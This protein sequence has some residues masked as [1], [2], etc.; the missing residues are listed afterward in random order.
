MMKNLAAFFPSP[1]RSHAAFHKFRFCNA[2]QAPQPTHQVSPFSRRIS[3]FN[4]ATDADV[5]ADSRA[6]KPFIDL[7]ATLSDE[8]PC[9]VLS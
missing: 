5:G 2:E 6:K 7:L 9:C 1:F 8:K 4:A 3:V